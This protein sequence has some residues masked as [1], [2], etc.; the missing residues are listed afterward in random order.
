MSRIVT[1]LVLLMI[2]DVS[3]LA[4]PTGAPE[5]ACKGMVPGH[6]GAAMFKGAHSVTYKLSQP[7]IH[8]D[9]GEIMNVTLVTDSEP[10]RGFMVKAIIR[11]GLND[12]GQFLKS[13]RSKPI[14][15]CSAATHKTSDEKFAII[16]HW[17]APEN[18]TG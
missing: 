5:A 4:L 1:A 18:M 14:S 12:N 15:L 6:R 16:L 9:K 10:F 17:K 8:F 7:K 11:G 13:D 3:I 2:V